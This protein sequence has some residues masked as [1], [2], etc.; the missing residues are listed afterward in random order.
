MDSGIFHDD[1]TVLPDIIMLVTGDP[2]LFDVDK[3]NNHIGIYAVV[4]WIVY[5]LADIAEVGVHSV[6]GQLKLDRIQSLKNHA[7]AFCCSE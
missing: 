5:D 3:G 1:A 6:L 4:V 7:L 2:V